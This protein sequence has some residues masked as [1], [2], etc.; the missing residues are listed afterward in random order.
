[1]RGLFDSFCRWEGLPRDGGDIAARID[2]Y[3]LFFARIDRECAA[4]SEITQER[5]FGLFGA[6]GLRRGFKVVEFFGS[7]LAL[8]WSAD[9]LEE[10]TE[11][12]RV[13]ECLSENKDK[14]WHGD[15]SRYHADLVKRTSD[16]P[17]RP[18]TLRMYMSAAAKLLASSEIA[19]LA[20]L[21][22]EH[23]DRFLKRS[24]G[25]AA[26]LSPFVRYFAATTSRSLN[27][28]GVRAG[29]VV[30]REKHLI[31]AVSTVLGR[32]ETVADQRERRALLAEAISQIYGVPRERVL[33]L[34]SDQVGV[35]GEGNVVLWPGDFDLV[36]DPQLGDQLRRDIE[37]QSNGLLFPGRNRM[38]RLSTSAARYH[39]VRTR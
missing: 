37:A 3:A 1:M 22:Q 6:E 24:P 12:R 8:I 11:I 9:R 28:P 29:D 27:V 33:A 14:P 23:V 26:N 15:L 32:L 19:G 31:T 39:L 35:N 17:L 10:L 2:R 38:Q 30:K 21:T 16:K 25:L 34:T 13:E 18:R 36:L 7:H 5:L 4:A 20:D